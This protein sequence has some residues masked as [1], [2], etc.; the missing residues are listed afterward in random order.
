MGERLAEGLRRGFR[1]AG[2]DGG[3]T[4]Y[5]SFLHLHFDSPASIRSFDDVNLASPRL[6]QMHR[7]CLNE[8]VYLAPRGML[9]LSTAMDD[10]VVDELVE[11]MTRAAARV[12]ETHA[13]STAAT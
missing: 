1:S 11:R 6:A 12:V 9:N 5:G 7:A 8:G 3:V 4:A 13:V 10:G 2:V